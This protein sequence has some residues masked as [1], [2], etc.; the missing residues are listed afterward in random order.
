MGQ[1]IEVSARM[2]CLL[3]MKIKKTWKQIVMRANYNRYMYLI[4]VISDVYI[5]LKLYIYI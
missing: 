2:G 4:F 3:L 1:K 5:C